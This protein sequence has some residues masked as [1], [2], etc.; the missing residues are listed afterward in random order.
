MLRHHVDLLLIFF[1]KH[2]ATTEIY[3]LSLHDALPIYGARKHPNR[4]WSHKGPLRR[5]RLPP[6]TPCGWRSKP[7]WLDSVPITGMCSYCSRVEGFSHSEIAAMLGISE[8][9]SKNMLYQA[10][11]KLR[12]LLSES[13]K[14]VKS[15]PS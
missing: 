14:S 13:E 9:S 6:I 12:R 2:P 5:R 10:K 11:R 3:T 8:A 1:F 15:E 7:V 4:T